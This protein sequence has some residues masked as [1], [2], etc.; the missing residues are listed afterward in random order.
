MVSNA[1]RKA[2][3]RL[4]KDRCT[5]YI[6]AENTDPST[7]LTV[8]EETPLFEDQPCKLSFETLSA[9]SGDEI[10][11]VTQS[12]KLILAPEQEVPPGSRIVVKR[13]QPK[14]DFEFARSGIPGVFNDHQEILLEPFTGYA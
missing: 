2:L 12:A 7:H 3:E 1:H 13:F 14:Q 10:P 6:Q 11:M 9:T 8:F 5:V 4:W